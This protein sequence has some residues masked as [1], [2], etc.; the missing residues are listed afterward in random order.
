MKLPGI[1]QVL[2]LYYAGRE[3]GVARRADE[4]RRLRGIIAAL[5]P[6]DRD[7][8]I[9]HLG[10]RPYPPVQQVLADLIKQHSEVMDPLLSSR[11]E[12]F[13]NEVMNTLQY[14]VHRDPELWLAA[15]HG[16]ALYWMMEKL[17]FLIKACFFHELG[18]SRE[19]IRALFA[20]DELYQHLKSLSEN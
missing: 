14:V 13:V 8:V 20:H 16:A 4:E 11:Q 12:G 9:D 19:K 3:E 15:S 2:S 10:V 5:A 7:W 17:R 18:F 6:A 1:V